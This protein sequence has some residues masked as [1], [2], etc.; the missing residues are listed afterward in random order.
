MLTL[1]WRVERQMDPP[2]EVAMGPVLRGGTAALAPLLGHSILGTES[3]LWTSAPGQTPTRAT[4]NQMVPP[5][6]PPPAWQPR[7]VPNCTEGR[8]QG[9]QQS[10]VA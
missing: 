2:E 1:G 6:A 7:A 3:W 9:T 8:G 10:H 4:V 5:A